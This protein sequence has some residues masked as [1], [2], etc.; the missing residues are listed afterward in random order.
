M[1]LLSA[2]YL[3][4]VLLV[5]IPAFRAGHDPHY[6]GYFGWL[7]DLAQT[8][9]GA[10]EATAGPLAIVRAMIE[11]PAAWLG[12]LVSLES[13]LSLA[14][15]LLP[16]GCLPLLS[17]GRLAVALPL[18]GVLCLMETSGG[19]PEDAGF[20]LVPFHH[21]HAPLIPLLF[22]A[23]AAG[24]GHA[25]PVWSKLRRWRGRA[26]AGGGTVRRLGAALRLDLGGGLRPVFQPQPAGVAVLGRRVAV[27]LAPAVRAGGT[28]QA[29]SR[30]V[31]PG[32]ARS[33]GRLDRSDSPAV[34][35]SRPLVRLQ[36]VSA[37]RQ[38]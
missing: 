11:H 2:G 26:V 36:P 35:A 24:M 38:Q 18:F 31:R 29:V 30:G 27:A 3:A 4:L 13:L 17:P 37:G 32:S 9:D 25:T 5:L 19:R 20:P 16:L 23:A 15:L 1:A 7:R 10:G 33:A 28:G 21:F 22:W 8:S 14:L 34:Y 6:T 12:R